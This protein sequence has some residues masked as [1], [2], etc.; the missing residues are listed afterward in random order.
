LLQPRKLL[1]LDAAG[2]GVTAWATYFLL[3]AERLSTGLPAGLLVSLAIVAACFACYDLVAFFCGFDPAISLRVIACLNVSY[4]VVVMVALYKYRDQ[5][6][7]LGFAYF[8]TE[9]ALVVSLASWEWMIASRPA[10]S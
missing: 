9:T 6:T 8:F 2:A 1:L 4:C 5:A 3:A 7:S 10:S